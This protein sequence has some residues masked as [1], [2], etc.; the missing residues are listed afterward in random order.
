MMSLVVDVMVFSGTKLLSIII[1]LKDFHSVER[2]G[3]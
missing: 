1:E 3:H 2:Q